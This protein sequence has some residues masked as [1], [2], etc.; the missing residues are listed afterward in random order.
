MA[1]VIDEGKSIRFARLAEILDSESELKIQHE[2]EQDWIEDL[3][4]VRRLKTIDEIFDE[5]VIVQIG[6][7]D[8]FGV[9]LYRIVH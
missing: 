4:H 8:P 5:G 9:Y 7:D 6:D 1:L 3:G 2:E